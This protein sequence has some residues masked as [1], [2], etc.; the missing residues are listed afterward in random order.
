MDDMLSVGG[1]NVFASEVE[2]VVAESSSLRRGCVIVERLAG[3]GAELVLLA[4]LGRGT[5][6]PHDVALE[7]A[8]RVGAF[9]LT[10]EECLFLHKGRLPK[11]P[12]GKIQRYR[13]REIAARPSSEDVLTAVKVA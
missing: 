9:G 5:R 12:S 8:E 2:A 11:T 13:C 4:E 1:R 6:D 10:L 3:S 7:L